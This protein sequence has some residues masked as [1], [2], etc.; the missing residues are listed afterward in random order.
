MR[1]RGSVMDISRFLNVYANLPVGLRS[2]I[3]VLTEDDIPMTW[4][5]AYVEIVNNTQLGIKIYQKLEEMGVI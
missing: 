2:E 3:V 5:A 4:N 1:A